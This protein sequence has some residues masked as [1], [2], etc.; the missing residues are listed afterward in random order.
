MAEQKTQQKCKSNINSD[1]LFTLKIKYFTKYIK[2]FD[3]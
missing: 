1:A 3:N 2:M